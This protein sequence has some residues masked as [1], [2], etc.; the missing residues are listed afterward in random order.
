MTKLAVHNVVTSLSGFV[1]LL[2]GDQAKGMLQ[3]LSPYRNGA[4]GDEVSTQNHARPFVGAFQRRS[5]SHCVVL[6]AILCAFVAK[7]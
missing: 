1:G 5:W 2:G 3:A 4:A 6:G 7:N